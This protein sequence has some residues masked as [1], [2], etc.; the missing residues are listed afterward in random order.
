M[1]R[2]LLS[3]TVQTSNER[4][5]VM[6]DEIAKGESGK[7]LARRTALVTQCQ[8]PG[9]NGSLSLVIRMTNKYQQE[10]EKSRELCNSLAGS[11]VYF[12]VE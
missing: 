10:L 7:A 3:R 12:L 1:S 2:G 6:S 11:P 9:Y 8:S 4:S 5:L